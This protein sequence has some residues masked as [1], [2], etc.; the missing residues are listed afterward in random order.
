MLGPLLFMVLVF[1]YLPIRHMRKEEARTA[2]VRA[3]PHCDGE[4]VSAGGET[5]GGV[6]SF[7]TRSGLQHASDCQYRLHDRV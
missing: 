5:Y 7:P 1:V 2:R 4:Y 3:C 6:D